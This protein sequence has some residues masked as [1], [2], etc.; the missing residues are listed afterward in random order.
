MLIFAPLTPAD[1]FNPEHLCQKQK[2]IQLQESIH[3]DTA[4][5]DH[6]EMPIFHTAITPVTSNTSSQA[7]H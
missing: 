2:M 7:N 3:L 4:W 1:T 5:T 6:Y